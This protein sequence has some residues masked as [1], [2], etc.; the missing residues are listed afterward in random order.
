MNDFIADDIQDFVSKGEKA[1]KDKDLLI[2]Y[3]RNLRDLI[4]QSYLY[5]GDLF[6][7][8]VEAEYKKMFVSL[9]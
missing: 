5:N 7:K 4:K 1:S 9:K 6:A 3:R 2:K 8:N